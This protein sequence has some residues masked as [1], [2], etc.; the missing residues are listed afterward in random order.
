MNLELFEFTHTHIMEDYLL[1]AAQKVEQQLDQEI[2]RLENLDADDLA[3]IRR[4]RMEEMKRGAQQKLEWEKNGHGVYSELKDEKEF[5][6][7]SKKSQQA[8]VH[9]Y[10][11]STMRCKIVDKHMEILARQHLECKF[12]KI[13]AERSQ[14]L[15]DRLK[16]KVIP[17]IALIK[18]HQTCDYI[19]GFADLGN[20][21]DFNTEMLEW[22]IAKAGIITYKG[23]L[24][25]P[26]DQDK[27]SHIN[28]KAKDGK[29]I[30]GSG[31]RNEGSDEEDNDW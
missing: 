22:R 1:T 4:N 8:V 28:K 26:P 3:A 23:D 21:D 31:K 11:N 25:T 19:V 24:N 2:D 12:M 10:R 9:F 18:N 29:I 17:T 5:F 6:E 13:D 14:F 15:V 27:K 7:A 30:R 16:I 20:S